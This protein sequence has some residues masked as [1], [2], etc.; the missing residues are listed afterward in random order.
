MFRNLV[1]R[2]NKLKRIDGAFKGDN[3]FKPI[4]YKKIGSIYSRPE[5]GEDIPSSM[6][7]PNKSLMRGHV[8]LTKNAKSNLRKN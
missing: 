1:V 8:I 6:R 3:Y 5:K 7:T 4:Q 2:K